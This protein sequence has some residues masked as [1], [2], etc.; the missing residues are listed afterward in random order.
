MIFGRVK[1]LDAILATAEKKSLHRTLGAR[2]L[3][4]L[5][6]PCNQFGGQDPGSAEEITSGRRQVS[7]RVKGRLAGV[8]HEFQ[9]GATGHLTPQRLGDLHLRDRKRV[10]RRELEIEF[11]AERAARNIGHNQR[12]MMF[13]ARPA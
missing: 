11:H 10:R 6:F 7:V 8:A 5:G 3:V 9:T 13:A 2:G 1:P 12:R 4:V